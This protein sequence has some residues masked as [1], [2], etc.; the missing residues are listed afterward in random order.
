MALKLGT[1]DG[2]VP[3]FGDLDSAGY[4]EVI[5]YVNYPPFLD[6]NASILVG[7][8]SWKKLSP[9]VQKAVED[10]LMEIHPA[11]HKVHRRLHR[12]R[13][14][15]VEKTRCSNHNNGT[16]RGA[17]AKTCRLEGMGRDCRQKPEGARNGSDAERFSEDERHQIRV[18]GTE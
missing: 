13:D 6:P 16:K 17:E 1:L 9:D 14:R 15:G 11:M 7:M 10:T 5:K 4:K 12:E 3:G 18:A 2:A 8:N